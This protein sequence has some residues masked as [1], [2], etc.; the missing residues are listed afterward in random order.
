MRGICF[1]FCIGDLL[2]KKGLEMPGSQLKTGALTMRR[3]RVDLSSDGAEQPWEGKCRGGG[4][5]MG[6]YLQLSC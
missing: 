6:P 3:T 1:S 5:S 4:A 2:S